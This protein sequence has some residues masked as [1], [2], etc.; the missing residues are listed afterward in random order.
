L[1][2]FGNCAVWESVGSAGMELSEEI[3]GDL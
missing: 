1:G 3:G 2:V